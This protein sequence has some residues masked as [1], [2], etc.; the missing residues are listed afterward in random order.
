MAPSRAAAFLR[1][2]VAAALL[3]ATR[4]DDWTEATLASDIQG[5]RSDDAP[6]EVL[7]L[8]EHMWELDWVAHVLS[9][10]PGGPPRVRA[11]PLEDLLARGDDGASGVRDRTVLVYNVFSPDVRATRESEPSTLESD[12]TTSIA[13]VVVRRGPRFHTTTS[14]D[15][16]STPGSRIW[17]SCARK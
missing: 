1:S 13:P 7:V 10:L 4:G 11:L 15:C 17:M 14:F 12:S 9:A 8:N 6:W 16:V 3:F 5:E 2:L